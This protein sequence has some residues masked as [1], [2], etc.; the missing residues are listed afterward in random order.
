MAK[1]MKLVE[2][3]AR[4]LKEWPK[5]HECYGPIVSMSQAGDHKVSS[6]A[7]VSQVWR[8]SREDWSAEGYIRCS[9][10]TPSQIS[11]DYTTAIV[12]REMWESERAKLAKQK[13][14]KDGWRRHRGGKQPVANGVM[15]VYRMRSGNEFP[16]PVAAEDVRWNHSSRP[17]DIMAYKVVEQPGKAAPEKAKE[18]AQ[19]IETP[20]PIQWRDRVKELDERKLSLDAAHAKHTADIAKER[21]DLIGKLEAQGLQLIDSPVDSSGDMSD[22]KN[23][24][25]GDRIQLISEGMDECREGDM[26]TVDCADSKDENQPIGLKNDT[27]THHWPLVDDGHFNTLKWHSRPSK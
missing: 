7:G 12:T 26:L 18:P 11:S 14:G 8:D 15:V 17:G 25:E 16:F 24:M 22:W 23:W 4:E 19:A 27:G 9:R 20:N 21:E 6:Y 10:F 5:A 1:K 13:G 3:L 2:I